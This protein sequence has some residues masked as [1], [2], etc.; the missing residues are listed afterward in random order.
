MGSIPASPNTL[1]VPLLLCQEQ[2]NEASLHDTWSTIV[3]FPQNRHKGAFTTLN[4]SVC[5]C[6]ERKQEKN[7]AEPY[8]VNGQ[9]EVPDAR[10]TQKN[11]VLAVPAPKILAGEWMTQDAL[12][13]WKLLVTK[14]KRRAE[15]KVSNSLIRR[16][17]HDCVQQSV[18]LNFDQTRCI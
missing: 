5:L 13:A 12:V 17:R 1:N 10:R 18:N 15:L 2:F 6:L 7:S 4:S 9:T 11:Q 14:D 3:V 8:G 16:L